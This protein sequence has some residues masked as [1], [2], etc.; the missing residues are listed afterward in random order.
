M[1]SIVVVTRGLLVFACS[2]EGKG[3]LVEISHV[4]AH[5]EWDEATSGVRLA[6]LQA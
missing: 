1:S 5:L 2:V 6:H 4:R 3:S